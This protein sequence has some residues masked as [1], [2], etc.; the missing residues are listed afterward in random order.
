MSD[1]QWSDDENSS[2]DE[3]D[4]GEQTTNYELSEEEDDEEE[5]EYILSLFKNKEYKNDYNSLTKIKDVKQDVKHK[6]KTN[7][8]I[9]L[10]LKEKEV[11]NEST[12]KWTS[13]RM[14]NTKIKDGK[15]EMVVKRQFKPRLPIP[16]KN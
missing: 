4:V 16:Q 5:R 7:K 10:D 11:I 12:K 15:I 1:I 8:K 3:N 2:S 6:E 9:I 14:N 13:K